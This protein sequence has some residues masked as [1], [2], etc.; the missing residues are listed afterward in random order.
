M[1][2]KVDSGKVL[3]QIETKISNDENY[4]NL[5]ERLSILGADLLITTL[6][7]IEENKSR[8]LIQ[9]DKLVTYAPKMNKTKSEIDWNLNI[10]DIHNHIRAFDPQPGAFSF[11]KGKRVKLFGSK[12]INHKNDYSNGEIFLFNDTVNIA[13]G[14]IS[15]SINSIQIE[16]KSKV[17]SKTF[18]LNSN[19]KGNRFV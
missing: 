9:N 19:M 10:Q 12:I 16:G 5:Q 3:N 7:E 14:G 2:D 6:N 15:L 8:S 13:I 1:S 17:E 4:G 18:Y 11:L